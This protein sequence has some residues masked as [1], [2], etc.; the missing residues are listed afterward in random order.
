[1]EYTALMSTAATI[2]GMFWTAFGIFFTINSFL[3]AGLGFTYSSFS[4]NVKPAFNATLQVVIPIGG[5]AVGLAAIYTACLLTKAL[6]VALERGT[7]IDGILNTKAFTVFKRTTR[8]SGAP[9]VIIALSVSFIGAWW[10][11]LW[12]A[13]HP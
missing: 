3:A 1:M 4:S 13:L 6:N 10:V 2:A 8:V 7:Q 9:W 11:V 12:P 5:I